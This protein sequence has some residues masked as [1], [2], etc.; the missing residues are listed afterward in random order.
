MLFQVENSYERF[1]VEKIRK[2]LFPIS[3]VNHVAS[4]S[5]IVENICSIVENLPESK[6]LE[7]IEVKQAA[8]NT[9]V[10]CAVF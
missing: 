8:L 6:A 3:T 5:D 7:V 9:E 4:V 2:N 10:V 1:V